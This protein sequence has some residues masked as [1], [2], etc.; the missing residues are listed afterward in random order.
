MSLDEVR[1]HWMRIATTN[2]VTRGRSRGGRRTTGAKGVGRF[3]V[4]KLAA[5]L[6][7]STT[8]PSGQRW[9][10]TEVKFDWDR[11]TAGTNLASI[12]VP[13]K[14]EALPK[15]PAATILRLSRVRESWTSE[16]VGDVQSDLQDLTP[17]FTAFNQTLGSALDSSEFS[18]KFVAPEFPE[19]EGYL[20]EQF[21]SASVAR[22]TG[23]VGPEGR[24][25]FSLEIR[26]R[27]GQVDYQPP[28]DVTF[29]AI[30]GVSFVIHLF[31][32]DADSFLDVGLS[33]GEARRIGQKHGGV[34]IYL[35]GFRVFPYGDPGDDWLNLDAERGR[36]LTAVSPLLRPL[37]S[38]DLSRPM[39]RLPGNNNLFGAVYVSREHQPELRPTISRERFV[40]NKAY[41]AVVS[42]ARLGIDWMVIE[43]ARFE[44]SRP[45]VRRPVGRADQRSASEVVAQTTSDIE[46]R[47]RSLGSSRE[48][49]QISALL[50]VMKTQVQARERREL[51]KVSVLRILASAGTMVLIFVHQMRSV[52]DGL[53]R[54]AR[55]LGEV[56]SPA[57]PDLVENLDE[58][59][60]GLARWTN[61]MD[62]QASQLGL[63]LG[64]EARTRSR[65]LALRA[66][67]DQVLPT[68]AGY[69]ADMGIELS[70]DI[71]PYLRTPAMYEAE[72]HS[73]LLNLLTNA[74]KA[75]KLEPIRRVAV[76]ARIED[77]AL[78]LDVL[79]TGSGLPRGS[80]D[81]LFEPFVTTS[82]PDPVLG[83]GTGLGLTIVRDIALDH[84]G[85]VEFVEAHE[86]WRTVVRVTIPKQLPS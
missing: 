44:A 21:L 16:D 45:Q 1:R 46:E 78:Q 53:R 28:D 49:R 13:F 6:D 56:G 52:L 30:A 42:F 11:F 12:N 85:S 17:P 9:E 19:F 81:R 69:A 77:G 40:E 71:P 36:R 59:R 58:M 24:P 3:A 80:S 8:T 55:D 10:H 32:Y 62:A 68:F 39:L 41:E 60:E 76:S 20:S 48:T 47:L 31:R 84:G 38:E 35:D 83:V 25:K 57:P 54:V 66:V 15:G 79:D 27:V 2:K 34:K 50:A 67:V 7:L 23:S 63:L 86:S 26:G 29:P 22:L 65:N 74:L 51:D 14:S 82:A 73:I 5:E 70:T 18:V 64:Q 75:V 37:I 43:R 72:L 61:V 4:R 33:A